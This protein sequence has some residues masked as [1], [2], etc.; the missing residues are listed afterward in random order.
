MFIFNSDSL[1]LVAMIAGGNSM[2]DPLANVE[3][4]TP[5]GNCSQTLASLPTP[6]VDILLGLFNFK[7]L[8]FAVQ[9]LTYNIRAQHS[10]F[11]YFHL[12]Q[13]TI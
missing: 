2:T 1:G 8:V 6:S 4:F 9:V 11:N 7:I 13:L 12:H 5:N 3:I 10:Q